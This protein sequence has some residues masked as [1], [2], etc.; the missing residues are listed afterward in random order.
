MVIFDLSS[1]VGSLTSS[2]EEKV[3]YPQAFALAQQDRQGRHVSHLAVG[4]GIGDANGAD[5][6]VRDDAFPLVQALVESVPVN[7]VTVG[8]QSAC[9]LS[10]LIERCSRSI[11]TRAALCTGFF[12]F[13]PD[14]FQR[15]SDIGG[16]LHPGYTSAKQVIRPIDVSVLRPTPRSSEYRQDSWP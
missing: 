1:R 8:L 15:N 5:V 7:V 12:R 4:L 2:L 6:L 16:S 10:V 14:D 3:E 9:T 11:S 13:L